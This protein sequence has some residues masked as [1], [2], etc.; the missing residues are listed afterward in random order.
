MIIFT[1][2][3]SMSRHLLASNTTTTVK[4][5]PGEEAKPKLYMLLGKCNSNALYDIHEMHDTINTIKELNNVK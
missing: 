3:L 2:L 4:K 1:F 5:M